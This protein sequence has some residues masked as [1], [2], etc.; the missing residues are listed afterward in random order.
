MVIFYLVIFPY[1]IWVIINWQYSLYEIEEKGKIKIKK[2]QS[3]S[4]PN[5]VAVLIDNIL[6][7]IAFS[8]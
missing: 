2:V 7:P 4:S 8:P 5:S 3:S 6:L 1:T